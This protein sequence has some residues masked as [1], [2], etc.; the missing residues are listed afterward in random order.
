MGLFDIPDIDIPD[1]DIP[2]ID[3][4]DIDIPDIDIP[5]IDIPDI[6][7][8]IDLPP[9]LDIVL[10]PLSDIGEGIMSGLTGVS[11]ALTEGVEGITSFFSESVGG[12]LGARSDIV[13][14]ALIIGG[15]AIAGIAGFYLVKVFVLKKG[16]GLGMK[17]SK[18]IPGIPKGVSYGGMKV[19]R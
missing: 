6:T 8:P 14:W 12:V 4:P 5:D 7:D 3:I 15:V 10:D 17:Y 18:Q 13:K 19:S 1:I 16:A 2:D 9:V 11:E